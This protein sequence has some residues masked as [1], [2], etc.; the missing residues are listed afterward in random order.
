M[1]NNISKT[2]SFK[3]RNTLDFDKENTNLRIVLDFAMTEKTTKTEA[4][5]LLRTLRRSIN[6][7]NIVNMSVSHSEDVTIFDIIGMY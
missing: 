6:N 5:Q 1:K 7:N 4:I 3:A 2:Q